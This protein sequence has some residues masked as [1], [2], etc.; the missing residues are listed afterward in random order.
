MDTRTLIFSLGLFNLALA[1]AVFVFQRFRD[2]D[3]PH[4][5]AWQL[6][7]LLT[8]AGFLLG[9]ARPLLNPDWGSWNYAGNLLQCLGIAMELAVYARYLGVPRW[10]P[11]IRAV[12][13]VAVPLFVA[14]IVLA[15][16]RHPMILLGT[17]IAALLYLSMSVLSLSQYRQLPQILL[18]M[19]TLDGILGAW[20]TVKVL[21]GLTGVE[22][23]SYQNNWMN[24]GLYTLAF[25]VMCIN[26]FCFL[27]LVQHR[28]ER[29]LRQA[30]DQVERNE[31][32]EREL[33]RVAAHEFRTPAA[34]IKTSLD[35]LVL[36]SSDL[37]EAVIHRHDNI[38]QAVTRMIELAGAII[39]RDRLLDQA[40][41]PEPQ[42]IPVRGLL[43][44][45][46]RRYPGETPLTVL[47]CPGHW[48]VEADP[49]LLHIALH[50]LIDNGLQHASPAAPLLLA[51]R[52]DGPLGLVLSVTDQGPGVPD[53]LKSSIFRRHHSASGSLSRGVG[54]SIVAAIAQAHRGRAWVEDHQPTG[55]V[56]C[57]WLPLQPSSGHR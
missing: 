37:P 50:N 56:F 26:G 43:D 8:G 24:V 39:S 17:G 51:A 45:I 32:A 5:R 41:R 10:V 30:L 14:T 12:M 23:V 34:I 46:A 3:N 47:D 29:A 9:W 52:H 7:K 54:L 16:S 53:E 25:V 33:L 40:V 27:L 20:L 4:L 1:L 42:A 15:G 35:S 44:E 57:L 18:L 31:E 28:Y 6:A 2:D 36:I 13:L 49:V 38:R 48:Q 55:S 19:G 22:L 21:V 11:V